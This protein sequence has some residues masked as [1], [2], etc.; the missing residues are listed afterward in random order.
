MTGP[1][2]Y[3][4][5]EGMLAEAARLPTEHTDLAMILAEAQV[6]ATLAQAAATVELVASR[7]PGDVGREWTDAVWPK[8]STS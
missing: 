1:E 3:R 7:G 8:A 4:E 2:H 5:A 6:H